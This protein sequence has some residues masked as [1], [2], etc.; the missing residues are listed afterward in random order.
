MHKL[1]KEKKCTY[2]FPAEKGSLSRA[3]R[4]W[5]GSIARDRSCIP[6]FDWPGASVIG[7][8][9]SFPTRVSVAPAVEED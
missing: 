3:Y 5:R 9:D 2:E 7:R 1:I 8:T 4:K 6:R